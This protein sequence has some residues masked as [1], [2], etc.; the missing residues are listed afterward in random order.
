MTK[1]SIG[2]LGVLGIC[3]AALG[4][5][6]EKPNVIMIYTDDHGYA[7]LGCQGI[8]DDV[9]TPNID[10]LATG[11]VRITD[12]HAT[13]PQ[14]GPSRIGLISG[15]YQNKL[16][17]ESNPHLHKPELINNFYAANPLP[18]RLKKAGYIS[19]MAGKS[20]L[21]SDD[22]GVLN[23]QVGFDKVFFKHSAAPGH[24]NMNMKGEDIKPQVQK[25]GYHLEMISDFGSTF[26]NRFKD[27]PFFLYLAYRAP[28][29]PLDAP[30]KY[31][32]RFPG[33][34]P[35]RRRQALAMISCVD[36]GVGQLVETLRENGIEEDTLIFIIGD[37][38][39]PYKIH[40]VDAPGGGPGWDGSLNDPMN[41]EKGMLT[42]G[43]I[44]V[45]FVVSWKGTIPG[46]Q[47]YNKPVIT[48]DVAATANAVAGLPDDPV[49]DGVNLIPYLTGKT[50]GAPHDTLYW[51]WLGQS[52]IRKGK[53]KYLRSDN[54]EY[55]FDMEND[56]I[57]TKNQ[58]M[59]YPEVAATLHAD[60]EK[61][62]DTL[63][64][65]GIWAEKSDGMSKNA[66]KYFNW[67]LDGRRDV[68]PPKKKK[69]QTAQKKG[70]TDRPLFKQRDRDKDGNVT[71]DE[72]LGGR[73]EKVETIRKNFERRDVDNDGIWE[74]SEVVK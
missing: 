33:E 2:L 68:Q 72:F 3:A 4:A 1:T 18:K 9:K 30:R 71:W 26:I 40:K 41:G 62:A 55:L 19:G 37:N 10:A 20:H 59:Q 53:W 74:K 66:N 12:G 17:L 70:P 6:R 44:R 67:Y 46:G 5:S 48:L 35:E 54:R 50:Q 42:E 8:V 65:P 27:Q 57:E 52:T 25:G 73:T 31:L 45:P 22:S 29:V 61:W 28:H 32:D 36:D 13:A 24:W 11:G 64:P 21:G 16:G 43:G 7:D 51:R 60:L 38:G 58:I 49:L 69:K 39:A 63:S 14:C 56:Y 15:Q 34:M 23:Q 47:V